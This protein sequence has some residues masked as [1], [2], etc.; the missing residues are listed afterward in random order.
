MVES[1]GL[2]TVIEIVGFSRVGESP[3]ILVNIGTAGKGGR[4]S[5][6]NKTFAMFVP[7]EFNIVTNEFF[8]V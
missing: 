5:G 3:F 8:C 6:K 2:A 7:S 1:D 4:I